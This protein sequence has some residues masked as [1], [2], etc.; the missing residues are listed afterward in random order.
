[1]DYGIR[2]LG[3]VTCRQTYSVPSFLAWAA[4]RWA[5]GG[6]VQFSSFQSLSHVR[7]FVTQWTE[8][9]QASLSIANSWSLLKLMS[10]ELVISSN[11]LIL[12]HPLFLLPSIF[13]SIRVFTKESVLRIRCSKY[14]CFSITPFSEYLALISLGLTGLISFCPRLS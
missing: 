2:T 4:G 12:C 11:H 10:L 1:M 13:P 7:P 3:S 5:F 6:T 9:R 14:W 8:A